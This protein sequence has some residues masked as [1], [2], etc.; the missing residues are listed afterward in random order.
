MG[1]PIWGWKCCRSDSSECSDRIQLSAVKWK[2]L[3]IY[4]KRFFQLAQNSEELKII[5]D[6]VVTYESKG[7]KYFYKRWCRFYRLES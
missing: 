5:F 4:I 7:K 1:K 3:G 2:V 6:G